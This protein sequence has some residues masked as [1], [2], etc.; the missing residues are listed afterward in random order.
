MTRIVSL[1]LV[2][3]AVLGCDGTGGCIDDS[4][5][6]AIDLEIRDSV[7]SAPIA[8]N[9]V[10]TV[11]DGAFGDSLSLCRQASGGA[12]LSRCGADERAGTYDILVLHPTHQFWS[13]HGVQVTRGACHV[14]TV[15]LQVRM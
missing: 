1:L 12:W 4:R 15:T 10:A 13:A 6:P 3:W 2:T 11:L 9:A 8:E 7:T 14:N 5:L